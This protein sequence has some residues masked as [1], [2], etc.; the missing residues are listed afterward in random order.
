MKVLTTR[1][2]LTDAKSAARLRSGRAEVGGQS[3][4]SQ[5][6]TGDVSREIRL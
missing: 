2:N 6:E 1:E 3:V 5:L 4:A